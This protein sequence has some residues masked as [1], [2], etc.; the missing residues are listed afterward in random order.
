MPKGRNA[1][2]TG[3]REITP[4][5]EPQDAGR[6]EEEGQGAGPRQGK[7]TPVAFGFI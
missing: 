1:Q 7:L 3:R 4:E 6:E 2:K 5:P